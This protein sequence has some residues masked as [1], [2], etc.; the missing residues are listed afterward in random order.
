LTA[1]LFWPDHSAS[2]AKSRWTGGSIFL[3]TGNGLA[4]N[5]QQIIVKL[6]VADYDMF[7]PEIVSTTK[8]ETCGE[9]GA[10]MTTRAAV[11]S[12]PIRR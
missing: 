5:Q 2:S 8:A 12:H 4:L 9:A 7:L 1:A 11:A 10:V 3:V 6:E